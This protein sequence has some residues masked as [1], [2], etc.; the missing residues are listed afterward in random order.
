MQNAGSIKETLLSEGWAAMK[1]QTQ[2]KAHSALMQLAAV[3][4]PKEPSDDALR[5]LI[6]GL[7]WV[8]GFEARVTR[9]LSEAETERNEHPPEVSGIGSPMESEP[10]E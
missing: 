8:L 5:G 2:E 10:T 4:R 1:T 6:S 3:T 7:N 9:A